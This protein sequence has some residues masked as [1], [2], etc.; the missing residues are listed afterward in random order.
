M[1][2]TRRRDPA[3]KLALNLSLT[4]AAAGA[5]LL[6]IGAWL[7]AA[8][9][10]AAG[11]LLAAAAALLLRHASAQPRPTPLAPRTRTTA[12]APLRKRRKPHVRG[13]A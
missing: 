9:V 7:L 1:N 10:F 4:C 5:L 13:R 12:S 2:Q 6:L 3:W 11:L 8:I